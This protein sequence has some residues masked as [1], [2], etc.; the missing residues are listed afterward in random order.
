MYIRGAPW[1]MAHSNRFWAIANQKNWSAHFAL[2]VRTS[3]LDPPID[4]NK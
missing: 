3:A 4:F 2:N 1:D